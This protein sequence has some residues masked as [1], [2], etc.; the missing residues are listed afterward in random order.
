MNLGETTMKGVS[1]YLIEDF[2]SI[3]PP[4]ESNIITSYADASVF[5]SALEISRLRSKTNR[6][7]Y[8][9]WQILIASKVLDSLSKEK[10]Y[11][12]YTDNSKT[13][14][15]IIY[16]IDDTTP[17]TISLKDAGEEIKSKSEEIIIDENSLVFPEESIYSVAEKAKQSRDMRKRRVYGI[18]FAIVA[19]IS[20]YLAGDAYA[21]HHLEI[22]ENTKT[23]L[24]GKKAKLEERYKELLQ[25]HTK[26]KHFPELAPIIYLLRHGFSFYVKLI[27]FEGEQ[28]Q[29]TVN[30]RKIPDEAFEGLRIIGRK[31]Q[32]TGE[33]IVTYHL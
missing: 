1:C 23:E 32:P 31:H 22:L 25:N 11:I 15:Q 17:H 14:G 19:S 26:T 18:A 27:L 7:I 6:P 24:L 10:K 9:I 16:Y 3:D 20:A 33:I 12:L 4:S 28:H 29:I 30:Q 2:I 8:G 13:K 21:S 5:C